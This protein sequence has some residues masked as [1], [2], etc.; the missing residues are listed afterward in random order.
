MLFSGRFCFTRPNS[1]RACSRMGSRPTNSGGGDP[2]PGEK[3]FLMGSMRQF[4]HIYTQLYKN[5]AI[6]RYKSPCHKPRHTA[7]CRIAEEILHVP[8][9]AGSSNWTAA[10]T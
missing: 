2:A 6:T 9:G 3:G 5:R 4:I 7:T 8:D 10:N 1:M